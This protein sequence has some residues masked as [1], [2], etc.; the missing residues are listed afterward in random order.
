MSHNVITV[1]TVEPNRLGEFIVEPSLAISWRGKGTADLGTPVGGYTSGNIP[2]YRSNA[3]YFELTVGTSVTVG[4]SA[5]SN[6]APQYQSGW[7]DE[8]FIPE[9]EYLMFYQHASYNMTGTFAWV[10]NTTSANIS[11]IISTN[12]NHNTV[13]VRFRVSASS[14]GLYLGCR[15]LSGNVGGG[16]GPSLE[17]N[18]IHIV[19]I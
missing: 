14:G 6:I 10:N 19:K 7:F 13:N 8:I 4:N 18:H 17:A 15:I 5:Y 2:F 11:P 16:S 3:T 1:N 9:G 12:S